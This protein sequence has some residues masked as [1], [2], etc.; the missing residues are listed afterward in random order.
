ML[1]SNSGIN[2]TDFDIF[3]QTLTILHLGKNPIGNQGVRFL[4]DALKINKV[5]YP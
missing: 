5:S 4:A 1:R 3:I 2:L